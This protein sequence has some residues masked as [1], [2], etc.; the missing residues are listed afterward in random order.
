MMM[1]ET[2]NNSTNVRTASLPLPVY[3][4]IYKYVSSDRL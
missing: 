3:I 4:I 2:E 1:G